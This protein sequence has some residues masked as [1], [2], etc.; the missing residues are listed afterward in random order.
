MEMLIQ[1]HVSLEVEKKYTGV[2]K[3]SQGRRRLE[4]PSKNKTH[5]CRMMH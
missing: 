2:D 3:G 4:P 5:P 1:G